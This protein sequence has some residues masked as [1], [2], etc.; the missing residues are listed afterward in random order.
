[1][2]NNWRKTLLALKSVISKSLGKSLRCTEN[3]MIKSKARQLTGRRKARTSM[4]L[5]TGKPLA[6]VTKNEGQV[7]DRELAKE[8][9][10]D[11]DLIPKENTL[12]NQGGSLPLEIKKGESCPQATES[13]RIR[14]NL[15]PKGVRDDQ[16]EIVQKQKTNPEGGEG[17]APLHPTHPLLTNL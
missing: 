17:P 6:T 4:A 1:M 12:D 3:L 9:D 14:A 2:E 10:Q 7:R 15:A 13:R 5:V 8:G 11:L 16:K